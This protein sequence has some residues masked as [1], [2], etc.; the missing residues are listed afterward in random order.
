M[1]KVFEHVV[2]TPFVVVLVKK[3]IRRK[4]RRKI[5]YLV[6]DLEAFPGPPDELRVVEDVVSDSGLHGR[7]A[8][9][10]VGRRTPETLHVCVTKSG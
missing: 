8:S 3:E 6:P 1:K 7:E 2:S 9:M 5:L 10:F 4:I